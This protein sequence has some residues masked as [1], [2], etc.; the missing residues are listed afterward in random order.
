M[1]KRFCCRFLNHR[2]IFA[3]SLKIKIKHGISNK[4]TKVAKMIPV[5]KDTTIGIRNCACKLVSSSIGNKPRLVV[6][7]VSR[8]GLKRRPTAFNIASCVLSPAAFCLLKKS[9]KTT[10]SFT[11]TPVSATIPNIEIPE[12]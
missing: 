9:I 10:L 12:E 2:A 5:A 4:I 8:I 7:E 1:A 6:R 3:I 11:T